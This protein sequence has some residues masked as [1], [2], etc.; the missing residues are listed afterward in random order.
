MSD[1]PSDPRVRELNLANALLEGAKAS[2][3]VFNAQQVELVASIRDAMF[4][5]DKQ[6]QDIGETLGGSTRSARGQEE[7]NRRQG[8]GTRTSGS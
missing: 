8:T 1:E 6:L 3:K 4:R 5:M 7:A 2:P